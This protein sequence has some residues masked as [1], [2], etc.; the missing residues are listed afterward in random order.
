[1]TGSNHEQISIYAWMR[2]YKVY[3]N[4]QSLKQSGCLLPSHPEVAFPHIPNHLKSLVPVI[5]K[6]IEEGNN[7]ML[8]DFLSKPE[9]PPEKISKVIDAFE[10]GNQQLLESLLNSEEEDSSEEEG[11]ENI[12]DSDENSV[13][14]ND[15][16]NTPRICDSCH[17]NTINFKE[18]LDQ[19]WF[20]NGYL[21]GAVCLKCSSIIKDVSSKRSALVCEAHS[22]CVACVC[23]DCKNDFLC[24]SNQTRQK[25][26]KVGD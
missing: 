1:V 11:Q 13:D 10:N 2:E 25:R 26:R 17:E 20:E 4:N 18:Y 14:S 21:K 8:L 16:E 19:T 9:S 7:R 15:E 12:S 22:Y 6:V 5:I 23:Y 24:N 3:K